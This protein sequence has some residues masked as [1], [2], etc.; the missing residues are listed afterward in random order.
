MAHML[1]N[2]STAW[3]SWDSYCSHIVRSCFAKLGYTELLLPAS[4]AVADLPFVSSPTPLLTTIIGYLVIVCGSIMLK[5]GKMESSK[6]DPVWIRMFVQLH[7][8][9]LVFLSLYMCLTLVY[10][11]YQ[12]GY[13][14]WGNG[15]N[16]NHKGMARVIYVFYVS[17]A[18]EFMDTVRTWL[19]FVVPF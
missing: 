16:V 12:N 7:N 1:N 10:E 18:Y 8:V 19:C 3:K 5:N 13:T 2:V 4:P 9:V 11:A 6:R 14:F 17:K 15:Y